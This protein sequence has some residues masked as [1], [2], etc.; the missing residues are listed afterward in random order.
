MDVSIQMINPPRAEATASS[1]DTMNLIAF[2]EKEF[3]QVRAILSSDACDNS[4]L[5]H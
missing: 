5:A 1:H 2:F 4:G 3:G